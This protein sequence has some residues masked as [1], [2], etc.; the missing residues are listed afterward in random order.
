MIQPYK[1]SI[2]LLDLLYYNPEDPSTHTP[3]PLINAL[4]EILQLTKLRDAQQIAGLLEV[5]KLKLSHAIELETEMSLK[6]LITQFR[7][8][9]IKV[10]MAEHP[11]RSSLEVAK[12]FDF[13]SKH[14]F[15]RFFQTNTGET[16][17]GK[18]SDA[19]KIDNYS[20]MVR[21]IREWK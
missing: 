5:D 14:A 19:P 2:T 15:W 18:K 16:P 9:Q 6:V 1:P 13:P 8:T 21:R 17:E 11:E 10:Y 20:K 12:Y 4:A 7:L 3:S